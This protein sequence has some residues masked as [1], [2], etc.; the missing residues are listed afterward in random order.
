MASRKESTIPVQKPP[1]KKEGYEFGGPLG[2]AG[3][4]FGLPVLLYSFVFVCN[5][6]SGCPAPSLLHPSTLA[7]DALKEE[8]GWPE[9]GLAAL[10]DA[11]VTLWVLGYYALCLAGQVF[12]PGRV[13]EG[14]VLTC[15]RRLKYKFNSFLFAILLLSGLGVGTYLNGADFAAWT[16]IWDNHVQ[17]ITA[18]M[19]VV[20]AL[21]IFVYANSF[22]IP[23]PGQP[24]PDYRE[25]AA[26]GHT[27]NVLYDLFIGRELNP[28]IKLPIPFVSD[29]S[30]T[31]DIK[32][33]CEMRPGL[34]GWVI[35]NL[36]NIAH[37]YRVHGYVTDSIVLITAFQGFYVLESLYTESSILTMIDTIMDGFGYMLAFGDL[38]WVP[39]LYSFQTR[40]LSI[41]PAKMGVSGIAFTLAVYGVGYYIFRSANAQK[42]RFRRNPDDPRVKHLKYITTKTGSKLL[43]SGWWGVARHINYF[44][45]WLM[46]WAFCLPTGVA[47]YIIEQS[48]NPATGLVE[49][50]AVQTPEVRGWGMIFTY[51]YILYFGTLLVHREARDEEKCRNKYGKDWERYT[52]IVKFKII[53]GVY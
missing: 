37:Q 11:R 42:D 53:P 22:T 30:R 29:V 12:L 24:N 2:A 52:S 8:I 32:V 16:F 25:L 36:S 23:A 4:I 43:I 13:H 44:G 45:D 9:E 10:F 15:G 35:L 17:L 33:L 39:F 28:R 14:T 49:K 46:S 5:D 27:G 18:N 7:W 6:V 20:I 1:N 50:R 47:G 21:S 3:I 19:L 41:F 48:L 31:I 38:V 40:Y 26:G 34:V 51:F